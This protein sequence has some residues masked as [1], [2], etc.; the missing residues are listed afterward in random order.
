MKW[1]AREIISHYSHEKVL[2]KSY[3]TMSFS[4]SKMM[5]NQFLVT[6]Y[7]N[8]SCYLIILLLSRWVS[9]LGIHFL[10][11]KKLSEH[12]GL[13]F[14]LTKYF[15]GLLSQFPAKKVPGCF[16][17]FQRTKVKKFLVSILLNCYRWCCI[18]MKCFDQ[19]HG[20]FYS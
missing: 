16:S 9:A 10:Y 3:D 7:I 5:V 12:I 17:I 20:P 13:P 19:A 14:W 18:L 6:D 15:C 2:L 8:I 11:F 4:S 1:W